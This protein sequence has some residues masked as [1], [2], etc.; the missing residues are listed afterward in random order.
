LFSL[1]FFSKLDMHLMLHNLVHWLRSLL[2]KS[3]LVIHVGT[4]H[5]YYTDKFP[6]H[7]TSLQFIQSYTMFSFLSFIYLCIIN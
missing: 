3:G 6:K 2:A 7:H 4:F 1:F 5:L